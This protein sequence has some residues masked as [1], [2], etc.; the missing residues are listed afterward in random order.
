[1]NP[2]WPDRLYLQTL[3]RRE[4]KTMADGFLAVTRRVEVPADE[5]FA[6]VADPANHPLI[7][8]SGM[9]RETVPAAR[10]AAVGDAF[11][12]NMHHDEWGAY[13]MRNEV[14]EFEDGRRLVWE[15]ARIVEPG[16]D[17]EEKLDCAH[18][19]WGWEF[20]PDGPDATQV[21]ETFDCTRSPQWLHEAVKEGEGWRDAMTA[22][23]VKLALL[24]QAVRPA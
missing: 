7:D 13:Q 20:A 16:P 5:L 4:D 9:V 22:S 24:A 15:P 3:T 18:Y 17:G 10:L 1:M 11:V 21:T 6:L 14:I 23:L 2:S 19:R 12:M 8:G